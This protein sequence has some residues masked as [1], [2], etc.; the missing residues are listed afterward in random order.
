MNISIAIPPK[1]I[2]TFCRKWRIVELSLFGSVLRDDFHPNSDVD[3]LVSFSPE[4]D[5]G[6]LDHED[7][8]EELT[9]IL[10]RKVDLV[11]R[12][13]VERST[14]RPRREAILSTTETIYAEG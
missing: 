7:M 2:E 3:V 9:T 4:A 14:N 5:W 1:E 10:G 8:E 12:R 13:S 6:L 11:T